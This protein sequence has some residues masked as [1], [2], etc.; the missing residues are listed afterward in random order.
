MK[1]ESSVLIL[2]RFRP[3]HPLRDETTVF[4]VVMSALD[5]RDGRPMPPS[6]S[7]ELSPGVMLRLITYC[8]A[9][10]KYA[11]AEIARKLRKSPVHQDLPEAT[12]I[13]RFR[14]CNRMALQN[15]L[16]KT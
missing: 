10:G 6:N 12:D 3:D 7:D 8:Y 11:S 2:K 1:D 5:T 16:E 13:R 15:A 9:K 14:R 4:S